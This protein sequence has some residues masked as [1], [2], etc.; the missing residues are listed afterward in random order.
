MS[1]KESLL[2]EAGLDIQKDIAEMEARRNFFVK[3]YKE[4]K[5]AKALDQVSEITGRIW[6]HKIALKRLV[7]EIHAIA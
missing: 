4:T 3:L 6:G 1:E 2:R 7:Q 5:D